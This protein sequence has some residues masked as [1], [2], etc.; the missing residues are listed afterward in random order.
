MLRSFI[1]RWRRAAEAP[2]RARANMKA[3]LA[4]APADV[5]RVTLFKVDELASDLICCSVATIHGDVFVVD[6]EQEGWGEAIGRLEQLPGF[7]RD[8]FEAVAKPPFARCETV[9]YSLPDEASP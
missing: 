2:A 5:R 6:E 8:W 7:R 1:P 4:L 9:V 3:V